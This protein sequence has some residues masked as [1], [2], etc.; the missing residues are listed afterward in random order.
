MPRRRGR[1]TSHR[2]KRIFAREQV[3][4]RVDAALKE[5]LGPNSRGHLKD[6][7]PADTPA[8]TRMVFDE[9]VAHLRR[10]QR[11]ATRDLQDGDGEP[12]EAP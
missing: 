2:H 7:L 4:R 11:V 10:L 9:A 8:H 3:R 12:E 5:L 1:M 6:P